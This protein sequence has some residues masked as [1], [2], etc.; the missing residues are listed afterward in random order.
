M[1]PENSLAPAARADV[2][3]SARVVN[4][5]VKSA[6]PGSRPSARS[7]AMISSTLDTETSAQSAIDAH[8]TQPFCELSTFVPTARTLYSQSRSWNWP[9]ASASSIGVGNSKIKIL[10]N[11]ITLIPLQISLVSPKNAQKETA[12]SFP[13][14]FSTY[15]TME[16]F[17]WRA[18]GIAATSALASKSMSQARS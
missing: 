18:R 8:A 9:S 15:M 17:S 7:S 14:F 10:K 6:E 3:N 11:E 4:Y 1:F 16:M 5:S 13:S 12:H 2:K